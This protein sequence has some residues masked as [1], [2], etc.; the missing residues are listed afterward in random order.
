MWKTIFTDFIIQG[1]YMRQ[2]KHQIRAL[3]IQEHHSHDLLREYDI[4]V[5]RGFVASESAQIPSIASKLNGPWVLKSQILSGGRGKGYLDNNK[6]SGIQSATTVDE[7]VKAAENILGN[8]LITKQTGPGGTLVKKVYMAETV[9]FEQEYYLAMTIDRERFSPVVILS[10]QG[11]VNIE[12]SVKDGSNEL[13]KFW[14]SIRDGI[15][16][17]LISDIKEKL[18][19]NNFETDEIADI[20]KKM[21]QIFLQKDATL[22]EINPL[23]RTEEGKFV[24]LDAKLTFDDAAQRRQK[25]LFALREKEDVGSDEL[26]A[27]KYGLVYVRLDGNIGNVV[28]GAGLA[29]ATNDAVELYGGKSANF[30][31]AG[32][33]AT[34]ETMLGAFKIIIGDP[35]VKVILVNIYG[36]II[37]CDM[38]AESIIAAAAEIG[39]LKVPMVVRLQGTNSEA[40]LKLLADSGLGIHTE[41]EFGAAAKAAVDYAAIAT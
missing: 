2:C 7:A 6:G 38:I 3:S 37:R 36:G 4:P 22:L 25:E 31:D 15:D 11:G 34:K 28:N 21:F 19:F 13:Q 39:P 29:M 17:K 23:V 35:R 5:P 1:W 40:G 30:L 24:C 9:K 32:G 14:F 26:E 10:K 18:G 20:L 16:E 33:Q 41:S 8:H 12:S 27:E